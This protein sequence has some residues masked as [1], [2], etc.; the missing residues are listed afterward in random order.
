[1]SIV[2]LANNPHFIKK[3]EIFIK[4]YANKSKIFVSI[5]FK[6]ID[7][8]TSEKI[9]NHDIIFRTN[10]ENFIWGI[11]DGKNVSKNDN[12]NLY[13]ITEN[14]NLPHSDYDFQLIDLD[15]ISNF[16]ISFKN[17]KIFKLI[18]KYLFINNIQ[19]FSK[20]STGFIT[21]IDYFLR[22]PNEK[23]ILLGFYELGNQSVI[24]EGGIMR[25][26]TYHNFQDEKEILE[27]LIPNISFIN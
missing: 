18:K 8:I 12:I 21:I 26:T 1:M 6:F 2:I 14:T 15:K 27:K 16:L 5:K 22:F 4:N 3:N 7:L 11:Q 23:I 25:E 24:K 20:F 9:N 13:L 10:E 19:R 17:D